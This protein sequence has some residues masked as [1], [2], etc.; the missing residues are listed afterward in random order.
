MALAS[1]LERGSNNNSLD[2]ECN[3]VLMEIILLSY[4]Q[5]GRSGAIRA[6]N[7]FYIET[8]T[9]DDILIEVDDLI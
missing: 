2:M 9:G 4:T 6:G 7:I 3:K 5:E 8:N 1:W